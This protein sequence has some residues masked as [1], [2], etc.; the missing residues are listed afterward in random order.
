MRTCSDCEWG[1][2]K[3]QNEKIKCLAT[4]EKTI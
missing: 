3:D 2:T 4:V 1:P